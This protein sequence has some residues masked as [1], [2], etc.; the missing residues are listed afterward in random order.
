[1]F[2]CVVEG[3]M[4]FQVA[5]NIVAT[6]GPGRKDALAD[7]RVAAAVLQVLWSAESEGHCGLPRTELLQRAS[8]ILDVSSA[9]R[10]GG[11]RAC[12]VGA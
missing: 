9:R 12:I 5:D 10:G 3:V 8:R 7:M 1:M 6:L 4:P 2:V 11:S